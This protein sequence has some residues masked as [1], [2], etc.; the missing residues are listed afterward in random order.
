MDPHRSFWRRRGLRFP[1]TRGDGPFPSDK[2]P[3][4]FQF[5]PH[6]RG[7]TLG[8]YTPMAG[9]TVSSAR[10]GM[11]RLT[12]KAG[13]YGW[14]FPRTRGD[15]LTPAVGEWG[16]VFDDD[17]V[18]TAILERLLHHSHMITIRGEAAGFARSVAA[19]SSGAPPASCP[20]PPSAQR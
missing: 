20:P 16:R 13:L 5:P 19:A 1:R 12:Y 7:W 18:A 14:S 4:L 8:S 2:D 6:A 17:V 11:D 3:E 10:A 9:G 15:G